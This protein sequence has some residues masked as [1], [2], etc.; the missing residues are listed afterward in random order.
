MFIGFHLAACCNRKIRKGITGRRQVF[1][2]LERQLR[3][4]RSLKKT[5]WF[6]FTSVGEFEQTK[7]LIE[8]I[9]ANVRIVLTFF[10]PSVA[11]NVSDYSYVDAAVYLPFDTPR[12][13]ERLINL[14]KPTCL[15][16]SRYD[17]WPNLV[18]KA[19]NQDIPII[20]IAGTLPAQSKRLGRFA[21]SFFRCVHR[22]ITLHC[23]IS[24]ADAARFQQ[25]CSSKHQVVVTGDTRYDQ[26]YR[27][28]IAVEP[29]A[30]FFSGQTT[31]NRP[32]LIAGSTYSDD[33]KVL[34]EASQILREHTPEHNPHLIL[35][36]HEPTLER[37]TEIQ[38]ELNTQKLTHRCFSGLNSDANLEDTDVLIVDTVGILAKL[39]Q[40]ADIAFVGGSFHGSVHNVMEPAAMAKPVLFGPTIQNSYEASLLFEKG[41][42]KLVRTPQ[43]MATVIVEW[44]NNKEER[45]NAGNIGKQLIEE[46]LGAV[47]RTLVHL[48]K[49]M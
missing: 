10:S 29:D 8:A 41:A 35:V 12:N 23:A 2:K 4:A 31:L 19:S 40:L 33:E 6:H 5:A 34:L 26:V 24:E 42:A 22:H 49:Y 47:E 7:P 25:L 14:I 11:P 16:F 37:I 3:D 21:R 27:R 18:W 43:Q 38:K 32:I 48:R 46:N 28:A 1:K 20:V 45:I 36:P 39:Y 15:I 17:I 30:E 13:A 9:Y 44:L